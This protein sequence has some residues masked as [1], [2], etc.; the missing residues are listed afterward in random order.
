METIRFKNPRRAKFVV[1]CENG[2]ESLC[3]R[4]NAIK[5]GL[6]IVAYIF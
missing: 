5:N 2:M 4:A 1:V 3:K 6:K